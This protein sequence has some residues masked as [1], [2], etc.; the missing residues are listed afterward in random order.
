MVDAWVPDAV[1]VADHSWGL[2]D[3]LVLEL[4]SAD[5]GRLIL[6]VAGP[7]DHHIAREIRAHREWVAA[8]STIG[9]APVLLYADEQLNLLITGYLPGEL[10]EGTPAQSSTDTYRQ[11]GFLLAAFHQQ[12]QAYDPAWHDDMRERVE[13]HLAAPHR[14]DPVVATAVRTELSTWPVGGA[15][16]VPTHGDWQPRN[17]LID[18]GVVRVID[19]GRADLRPADT[20]LARLA[21]QDFQRAPELEVAFFEGY[22]S[23]PREPQQWRRTLIAEA[24]GTASWAYGVKDYDFE[25]VGHRLLSLL[26]P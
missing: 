4:D 25:A 19:F 16:V 6:K 15:Q 23:D 3:N 11:A 2:V 18:N 5:Q 21:R 12:L 1:V 7:N 17:W 20:D 14:I 10:L 22:G 24:V 13:R 26:Y 8:L 9:R